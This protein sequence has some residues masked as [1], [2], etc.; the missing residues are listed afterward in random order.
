[1]KPHSRLR[2]LGAPGFVRLSLPW[3]VQLKQEPSTASHLHVYLFFLPN[4]L[5]SS[6]RKHRPHPFIFMGTMHSNRHPTHETQWIHRTTTRRQRTTL[7]TILRTNTTPTNLRDSLPTSYTRIFNNSP[8]LIWPPL[9]SLTDKPHPRIEALKH[10]PF[11]IYNSSTSPST[12]SHHNIRIRT[13]THLDECK[14]SLHRPAGTIPTAAYDGKAVKHDQR[15]TTRNL[16]SVKTVT[17]NT[18]HP[19]PSIDVRTPDPEHQVHTNPLRTL[20]F[21]CRCSKIRHP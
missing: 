7:P 14:A 21:H 20:R 12:P 9:A 15:F 11:R 19:F 3:I 13:H 5:P 10:V 8:V 2:Y 1:M 16:D 6:P 17:N 18:A 4:A